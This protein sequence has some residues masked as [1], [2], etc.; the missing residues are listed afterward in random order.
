MFV[1]LERHNRP[2]R[3]DVWVCSSLIVLD[4]HLCVRGNNGHQE[5]CQSGRRFSLEQSCVQVVECS[6]N[7]PFRLVTGSLPTIWSRRPCVL[8]RAT[9][10]HMKNIHCVQVLSLNSH[11]FRSQECYNRSFRLDFWVCSPRYGLDDHVYPKGHIGCFEI[12]ML[13]RSPS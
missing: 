11:V 9:R 5:L 10:V 7:G 3:L 13:D 1:V 4:D 12:Y 8:K 6:S 2:F